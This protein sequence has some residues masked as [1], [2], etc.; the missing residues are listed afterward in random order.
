MTRSLGELAG[1]R[2]S[3]PMR[4]ANVIEEA[5]VGGPQV[6][7]ASVGRQLKVRGVSTTVFIPSVDNGT[8]T[9]LLDDAGLQYRI[10]KLHRPGRRA[11][12]LLKSLAMLG[13]DVVGLARAFR[14]ERFDLVHV[15]GGAW[16]IRGVL[17][18]RLSR[19]PC[20]WHLNDTSA[21][22]IVRGAFYL[23]ACTG[24]CGFVVSADR[25]RRYYLT[26]YPL[27]SRQVYLARP[28]V[29]VKLFDPKTAQPNAEIAKTPG[30][31][32][33]TV[34]NI[35]PLKGLETLL[36]AVAK[37][38]IHIPQAHYW[39]VGP[40]YETQ[41]TYFETLLRRR[42][43][44]GLN[45]VHFVGPTKDTRPYLAAADLFVCSSTSEAGP[46]SIWEA[47]S[48]DVPIVSTDVGDVAQLFGDLAQI[49]PIR[50]PDRLSSAIILA[51]QR[52][53]IPGAVRNRAIQE[54]SLEAVSEQHH[55]MYAAFLVSHAR[56]VTDD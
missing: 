53:K 34:A 7:I 12:L 26:A 45:N 19:T 52:A 1:A 5:R 36:E 8:F 28:P 18:A 32:V 17:A 23:V 25:V 22:W 51:L 6:R 39:I 21:P 11:A 54:V 48:M 38:N 9:E 49:V 24:K 4:V 55:N 29:D 44:L 15:S 27:S 43:A 42:D 13:P 37:T 3:T 41:R 33:I 40:V 47:A 2:E 20:L 16:Q 56:C 35:N 10:V 30:P 14:R 31:N 46:M 50:D